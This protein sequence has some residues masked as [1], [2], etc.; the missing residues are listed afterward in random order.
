MRTISLYKGDQFGESFYEAYSKFKHGS[1]TQARIFGRDVASVCSFPDNSN[2][3]F[4]SAP[5]NNIHTASNAFKDYLV[6]SCARQFM[7]RKISVK[8]GKVNRKYS[9]D[10]D[11]GKMSKEDRK[12]AI[13][14]D[15]FE[16]DKSV[17]KDTD[18]LIFVDD[19]KIT[20]SH[21]ERI[22]EMLERE[23]IENEVIFV[24]LAEY[25]GDD[26]AIE[27]RLNHHS[28]NNLLDI[29]SVIRNE[30]FIFNTRVVKYILKAEIA[31]FVSFIMYQSDVFQ[32]TLYS[33][34]ILNGYHTNPM[35]ETNFGILNNIVKQNNK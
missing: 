21:E 4:Y 5:H 25:T 8:Q 17:I 33:L 24:Y 15:L 31:H 29:N 28:I 9:Y 19:I 7:E 20:G 26:P 2:L 16:I 27:H 3:V 11:Y 14:S 6:G 34:S 12:K 13:S 32:D 1:K 10:N 18:I 22:I 35:Y 30:E 23:K